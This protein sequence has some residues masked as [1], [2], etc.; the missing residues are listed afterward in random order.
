MIQEVDKDIVQIPGAT[1]NLVQLIPVTE[2][3]QQTVNTLT[4]GIYFLRLANNKD[5]QQKIITQ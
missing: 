4:P 1:D 5:I 3:T 2:N